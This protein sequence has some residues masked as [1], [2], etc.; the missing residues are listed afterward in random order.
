MLTQLHLALVMAIDHD[1]LVL[2]EPTVG[3]D[4]I[5]R[6]IFYKNL[7]NDYCDRETT[8]L[9]STHQVEEVE[10]LLTHLLFLD[11]G[12]IVLD[13][14]MHQLF[15]LFRE[16]MVSSED[17]EKAQALKPIYSRNCLGQRAM[18]L[19]NMPANKLVEFRQVQAPSVADLFMAKMERAGEN[20]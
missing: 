14:S 17:F 4:I 20:R 11:R 7:L 16:V 1:L 13:C 15:D 10:L 8:I 12:K 9:I 19:E 18:I 5:Y 3:L 2:V 6:K